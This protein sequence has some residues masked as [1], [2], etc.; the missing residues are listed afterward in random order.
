MSNKNLDSYQNFLDRVR[1]RFPTKDSFVKFLKAFH[2]YFVRKTG[3]KVINKNDIK[4]WDSPIFKY[5]DSIKSTF[6]FE[7]DNFYWFFFIMNTIIENQQ[8]ILSNE[9]TTE[10]LKIKN[11]NYFIVTVND[12]VYSRNR[13][14]YKVP[15]GG[16]A[17]RDDIG[18]LT[19]I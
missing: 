16:Y 3:I 18:T 2:S 7:S 19:I 1:S 17:D 12:I 11:F 6:S 8:L 15:Y 13:Y 9:L 4:L 5:W 14:Q 10:N